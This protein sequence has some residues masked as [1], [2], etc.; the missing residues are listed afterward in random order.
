MKF[1]LILP[2]IFALV[3]IMAACGP[4]PELRSDKY[5]HDNSLISSEPCAAPCWNGI[6]P[7]ITS[8]RDAITIIEDDPRFEQPQTQAEENG[9]RIGALWKEVGGDDC[10]QMGTDDGETVSVILVQLA[11]DHTLGE[12]IEEQGEPTYVIGTPGNEDQAIVNVFYPDKALIVMVFVAGAENG[13][14]SRASEIVGAY[15]LTQQQMDLIVDVSS[16]YAWKG[17]QPFSAYAPDV[18]DADYAVTPSVTLTP[19]PGQ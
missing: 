19:T 6:T 9:P 1:R 7:G 16:L 3:F 4:P 17:Y 13:Q 8:W 18:E 14:L 15:Y 5:L 10:C 2:G 11:P 12:L